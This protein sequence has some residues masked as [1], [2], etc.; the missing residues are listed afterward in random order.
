[1]INHLS[2]TL[3]VWRSKRVFMASTIFIPPLLSA[4]LDKYLKIRKNIKWPLTLMKNVLK[5]NKFIW[6]RIVSTL[7]KP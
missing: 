1:M 5:F 3:N 6:G 4:K 7:P 2:R